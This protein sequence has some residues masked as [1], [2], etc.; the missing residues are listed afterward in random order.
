MKE[1]MGQIIRRLRKERNL[2]QE[3]LAEQLGVTFQAVSKWE[4]DAGLPDISQVIPLATVFN[5]STDVVFGIY[6][7]DHETEVENIIN[8]ARAKKGYPATRE[9]IRQCYDELHKGLEKYPNNIALLSQ[10]LEA[11]IALA[12]PENDVYDAENGE[13]IYKECVREANVVIKYGKGTTDVLRAHMIMV[14]L[15]SAYGN[16][17]AANAHAEEFPWRAD[18]TVHEM[19]AYIAHFAQDY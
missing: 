13:M 17:E 7:T 11:G 16:F 18:M 14:L 19:K 1:S 5:V 8:S 2:T 3:E 12:Y 4:N 15:H 10:C 6:G 9:G